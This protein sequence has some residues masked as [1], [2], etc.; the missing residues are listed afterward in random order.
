MS[1]MKYAEVVSLRNRLRD[2]LARTTPRW[3]TLAMFLDPGRF[4]MNPDSAKNDNT[5]KDFKI[6]DNEA[7]RA[8]RIFQAGMNNGATP[9]VRPWFNLTTNDPKIASITNIQNYFHDTRNV[10]SSHLQ[11]SNFYRVMSSVYK[12]LGI[13]SNSAFAMLPHPRFGFYFYPFQ[14]GTYSFSCNNEGDPE[15]F[16][17]DFS[18]TVREVVQNYAK[19]SE[20]GHIIWDNIPPWVKEQWDA[21]RYVETIVLTNLIA[22]NANYTGSQFDKKYYSYT[23]VQSSGSNL[24][25]QLSNGFRNEQAKSNLN[26]FVRT[27]GFNYFP[28]IIPRWEVRP[29]SDFGVQ[30]PGEIAMGDILSL[31]KMEEGRFEAI[32]KLLRPAMVGH[33][34]LRRH[35]STILPGGMTYVDDQGALAGFKP[36]FEVDPKVVELINKQAEVKQ[37]IQEAYYVN[38]FLTFSLGEV[39]THVSARE[40]DERAAERLSNL[41]PVM[42][43]LDQDLSSKV[44]DIAQLILG[45]AGRLPVK[46]RELQGKQIRPEY[47]SSL[48]QAAKVADMNSIE[49]FNAFVTNTAAGLQDPTLLQKINGA[50]MIDVY[51]NTIAVN[52]EI[53]V[54]EEEFQQRRQ[55]AAQQAQQQAQISKEQAAAATVK[56]LSQAKIGEG[57]MLDTYLNA[58]QV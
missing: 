17:R 55:M 50:K 42:S 51:A 11:V 26:P 58:S 52:P 28:V 14:V 36:A 15:M 1:E 53:L 27:Q 31:Q 47:I 35:G 38:M 10:I 16:Y 4:T 19:L 21:A 32:D 18:M 2:N 25:P 49:R 43:Q 40:T 57:S 48:A 39:K 30:G 29:G 46:P 56:D 13:F 8:L 41:A 34:S 23:Y 12:D 54:S 20:T 45:D 24:P 7:G 3:D 37:A 33:A 9:Q 5:R 6:I 22:P 44:I